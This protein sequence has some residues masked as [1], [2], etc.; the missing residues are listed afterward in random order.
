MVF[1]KKKFYFAKIFPFGDVGN[2]KNFAI[3]IDWAKFYFT[4]EN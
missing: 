3:N 4:I 2:T 1:I